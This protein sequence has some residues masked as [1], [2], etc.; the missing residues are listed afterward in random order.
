MTVMTAQLPLAIAPAGAVPVGLAACLVEDGDC[1]QV[2]INGQLWL[3]WD[4]SDRVMRRLAAVHLVRIKAATQV[5][6]AAAFGVNTSTLFRWQKRFDAAGAPGLIGEARGPKGPSKITDEVAA[7]IRARRAAG[8]TFAQI[9]KALSVSAGSVARVLAPA[10]GD[11][12]DPADD[13]ETPG[14]GIGGDVSDAV[15]GGY[16]DPGFGDLAEDDTET[17]GE[18]SDLDDAGRLLPVLASPASR[19]MERAMAHAGVLDHARP[20]FHPAGRVPLAGLLLAVPAL[21]ATGLID[22][23][24]NVYGHLAAGFYGLETVLLEAVLRTLAAEPRAEGATRINP[25]DLGRVLG[26]DRSPEVKTIR[27]KIAQLAAAGKAAQWLKAIGAWQLH[28][29]DN[30]VAVLYIDGHVRTYHGR[31]KIQKTHVSR[32]RF[33]APATVE[34]WIDDGAGRPV[35]MVM[36]KPGGSLTGEIRRLLP[37]IR[38]MI[39][40]GRRVLIGFDR[41]GWS[42]ALF[43]DM[44]ASGFDV[45]TWRKGPADDVDADLFKPHSFV[46]DHGVTRTWMLADTTV[47]LPLDENKPDAG[48][49]TLRQVTKRDPQTGRQAHILTSLTDLAAGEVARRMSYRWRQENHFRYGRGHMALDA[50]DT[51]RATDDDAARMVPNPA[52][53]AAFQQVQNARAGL[54][55]AEQDADAHFLAIATPKGG[56]SILTSELANR[57]NA[58]VFAAEARLAD[59]KNAYAQTPTRLPL[60]AVRPGQQVLETETKLIYHAI[61]SAAYNTQMTLA[62]IIKTDTG[63]ARAGREA[64]TLMRSAL[65]HTGDIDPRDG[66]L[67]VRLDPMPTARATAAITELCAVLNDTHTVFPDTNL[68]LHYSVKPHT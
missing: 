43:R 7:N 12:D 32:L 2:V 56:T 42:P 23:A 31:R 9:E 28:A 17:D 15:G 18:G 64:H 35:A 62:R 54:T 4:A 58:P 36:A 38:A 30:C 39:G 51:Y 26:L 55:R 16:G 41:E 34:T 11:G 59:A 44:I 48:T 40:D 5:D 6:V 24:R 1:G 45:I 65:T 19:A 13:G 10:A 14:G 21:V 63:Y 67:H 68:K 33:P 53:K 52:K 29:D 50:H 3:A 27:R 61:R 57:I 60:E 8:E 20:V 66:V 49:I 22:T 47:T 37:D 46:D 25:T